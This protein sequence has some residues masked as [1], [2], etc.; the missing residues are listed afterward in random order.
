MAA[1]VSVLRW[2]HAFPGPIDEDVANHL[3]NKLRRSS[4]PRR[5]SSIFRVSMTAAEDPETRLKP[6]T[7]YNQQ[8]RRPFTTESQYEP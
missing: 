1:P 7:A 2:T 8:S 4:S 6:Q 3:N 5:S